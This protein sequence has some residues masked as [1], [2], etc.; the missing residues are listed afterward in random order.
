MGVFDDN[1]KSK[2]IT[3]IILGKAC[4]IY[5]REH[6]ALYVWLF[7]K[8]WK[9][10]DRLYS[11]LKTQPLYEATCDIMPQIEKSINEYYNET[12]KYFD[13]KFELAMCDNKL[14]IRDIHF[15][16]GKWM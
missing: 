4:D 12:G 7:G 10:W 9:S 13:V 8:Y 6:G 3:E 1:I 5:K 15:N 11:E 2:T 16:E 14:L